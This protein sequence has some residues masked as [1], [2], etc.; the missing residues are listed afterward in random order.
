FKTLSPILDEKERRSFA[1]SETRVIGHDVV[2]VVSPE[3]WIT[4]STTFRRLADLRA[5]AEQPGNRVNR[6]AVGARR[7]SRPSLDFWNPRTS[8][9]SRPGAEAHSGAP[10]DRG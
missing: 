10:R 7:R 1:A 4:R 8:W 3:T 9:C 5:G 6:R 2:A